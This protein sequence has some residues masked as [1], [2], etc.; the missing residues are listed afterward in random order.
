MG[1]LGHLQC[2]GV[3]DLVDGRVANE[4]RRSR[5]LLHQRNSGVQQKGERL[6][7]S[8]SPGALP[9]GRPRRLCRKACHC[10]SEL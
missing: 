8:D 6:V 3:L 4:P 2:E 7:P 10:L 9:S 5:F 1:R